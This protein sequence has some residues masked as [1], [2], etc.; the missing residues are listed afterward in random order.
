MI[1]LEGTVITHSEGFFS[2]YKKET[3]ALNRFLKEMEQCLPKKILINTWNHKLD[4]LLGT[5]P[6]RTISISPH[7]WRFLQNLAHSH[8]K[9]QQ[10]KHLI[11]QTLRTKSR[12]PTHYYHLQIT[13][14]IQNH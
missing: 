5:P 9:D 7:N 2:G 3:L 1:F 12:P 14:I 8:I 13:N 11:N 6:S 10:L 4:F